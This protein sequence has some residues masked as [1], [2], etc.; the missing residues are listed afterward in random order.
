M[1]RL[2]AALVSLAL[3]A[4]AAPSF[5]QPT[6]AVQSINP[7]TRDLPAAI[8]TFTAQGAATVNSAD[9]SGFNVSR[10]TCVFRVASQSGTPSSVLT[11]QGKDTPSGQYYTLLVGAAV[12][13]VSV[14]PYFVG[15]GIQ[16]TANVSAA[17]PIP[18][19]WRVSTTVGGTTPSITGTI[20]CSVS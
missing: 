14:N 17:L 15:A 10:V 4:F 16:T 2:A 19:F 20:G 18:R 6:G 9:Q 13:T 12:T 5:S 7:L 1:K 8:T 11:I 3:L